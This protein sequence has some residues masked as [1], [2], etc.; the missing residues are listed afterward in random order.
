MYANEWMG[1]AVVRA[2][3]PYLGPALSAADDD[4]DENDGDTTPNMST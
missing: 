2:T 4:D 1:R 3:D